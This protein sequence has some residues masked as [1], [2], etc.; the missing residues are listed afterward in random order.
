MLTNNILEFIFSYLPL[1]DRRMVMRVSKKWYNAATTGNNLLESLTIDDTDKKYLKTILTSNSV[2][3]CLKKIRVLTNDDEILLLIVKNYKN[4]THFAFDVNCP[5]PHYIDD[6]LKNN[7]KL[8]YIHIYPKVNE[9]IIQ[10][11]SS[12]MNL[13]YIS[14]EFL[15]NFKDLKSLISGKSLEFINILRFYPLDRDF[16]NIFTDCPYL[17]HLGMLE[18]ITDV[19]LGYISGCIFLRSIV[20]CNCEITDKGINKIFINCKKL[21]RITLINC[22]ITDI[23]IQSITSKCIELEFIKLLCKN[24]KFNNMNSCAMLKEI[25]LEN[26]DD[27]D[28]NDLLIISKQAIALENFSI[29]N[30]YRKITNGI[31]CIIKC[32]KLKY[33]SIYNCN[34]KYSYFI[35]KCRALNIKYDYPLIFS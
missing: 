31:K 29:S 28:N 20:L 5:Y 17:K 24:V 22:S 16:I 2:I 12:C 25:I 4:L 19:A 33:L 6:I 14:L 9:D 8:Q 15:Y 23:A 32:K 7:T 21:K 35:T 27:I 1:K 34:V 10:I 3:S 13:K 11:I 30:C 18:R 26:C